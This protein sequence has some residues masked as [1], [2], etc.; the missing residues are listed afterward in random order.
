[1]RLV[2]RHRRRTERGIVARWLASFASPSTFEIKQQLAL[3][4]QAFDTQMS[5][6]NTT[7]SDVIQNVGVVVK[8]TDELGA[9]VAITTDP[10]NLS[11]KFYLRVANQQNI[12]AT[13]SSGAVN[14]ASTAVINWLLIPAP[15]AAGVS[16][17]G[18]KYCVGATLRCRS[19]TLAAT[20]NGGYGLDLPATDGFV[21]VKL[22]DL[23]AGQRVLGTARL[24]GAK[25]L[26]AE[27]AGLWRTHNTHNAH[28]RASATWR[29]GASIGQ[30]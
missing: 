20:A 21:V 7:T 3:E 22:R 28:V 23:Y 8:V 27:N 9:P 24:A 16:A 29:F 6:N 26:L 10:N 12:N 18:K 25:A 30:V 4:R 14:P 5:I 11:A 15:G 2:R 1:V 19:A 17:L 13:D